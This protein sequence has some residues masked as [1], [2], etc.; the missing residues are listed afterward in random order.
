M[1]PRTRRT[2]WSKNGFETGLGNY[3]FLANAAL[4][5]FGIFAVGLLLLLGLVS[6]EFLHRSVQRAK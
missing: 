2:A 1:E 3:G 5:G 4:G 6:A